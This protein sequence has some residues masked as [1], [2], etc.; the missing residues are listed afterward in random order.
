MRHWLRCFLLTRKKDGVVK[1]SHML[2]AMMVVC[3]RLSNNINQ[4]IINKILNWSVVLLE[5]DDKKR[6][7]VEFRKEVAERMEEGDMVE[8]IIVKLGVF[9]GGR[10]YGYDIKTERL[11]WK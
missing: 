8:D 1:L 2:V 6:M 11:V 9:I 7:F 3:G 5:G 10:A 4:G